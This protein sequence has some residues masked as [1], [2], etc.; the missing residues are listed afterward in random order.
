MPEARLDTLADAYLARISQ[1]RGLV[2][3]SDDRITTLECG[4]RA[5]GIKCARGQC[6]A[7]TILL[8]TLR[9]KLAQ[10]RIEQRMSGTQTQHSL[11]RRSGAESPPNFAQVLA[12]CTKA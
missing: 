4:E 7:S 1:Y 3:T 11:R 5:H 12:S 2:C 8:Q 6:E 10:S 9:Q